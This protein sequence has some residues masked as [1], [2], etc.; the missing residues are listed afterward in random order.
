MVRNYFPSSL[1][2]QGRD[3]WIIGWSRETLDKA[4][5]LA[6][7]GARV[8]AV[9]PDFPA[10][11]QKQL[12][13]LKIQVL[14]RPFVLSD[15][16]KQ[17]FVIYCLMHEKAWARKIAV[18]CRKK[19]IL[20]CAIDQPEFCDV[21]NVSVFKKGLLRVTIGTGG[22]APAVSRKIREG[23]EASLKNVPLDDYLDSLAQLRRHVAKKGWSAE[24]RIAAMLKA[25]EG[26]AFSAR[27][28]LPRRWKRR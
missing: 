4:G 28:K 23:L 19:R 14:K 10:D 22:A 5:K 15:L 20:L 18:Q 25:A 6:E 13:R 17:F 16:K 9:A 3:C 2:V 27:V 12:R 21:V 8:T 24:K 7:A 1:N 11:A 26:F